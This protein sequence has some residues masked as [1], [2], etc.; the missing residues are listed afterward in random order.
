MCRKK[1]KNNKNTDGYDYTDGFLIHDDD[2]N[3]NKKNPVYKKKKNSIKKTY[4]T[5][6]C[7]IQ[8]EKTNIKEIQSL[9]DI[10]TLCTE[11]QLFLNTHHQK[12]KRILILDRLV[13]TI[14]S[15][16]QLNNMIGLTSIKTTITK[17]LL[18]IVQG[19]NNSTDF[20]HICLYG[21]P[22]C[23]K[24]YLSHI[25]ADIFRKIGLLTKGNVIKATRSDLIGGYLG[26][27]AIKTTKL[28]QTC[29][30]NVLILDEVY[31]LGSADSTGNGQ[32]DSFAKE[33]I[34]T[35]NFFLSEERH[36]FLCII[37]GYKEDVKNCFFSYNK[38]LERR[39]PW[40]YELDQYTITD[41]KHIFLKQI[42]D[43]QW[44]IL[45][46]HTETDTV[47][48]TIVFKKGN[49]TL[50]SNYGGDTEVLLTKCKIA[51][52]QRLFLSNLYNDHNNNNNNNNSEQIIKQ[53][54][55]IDIKKGYDEFLKSKEI[56]TNA[57]KNNKKIPTSV[58]MMYL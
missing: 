58:S 35:I 44:T 22:G 10:I 51:H 48:N 43:T 3:N 28:L 47:L 21:N 11:Y 37:F 53:L 18:Y 31:S 8:F 34:D 13:L 17:Q 40:I 19:L 46:D 1:N 49:E 42:K 55:N 33:C 26:S 39:F 7:T 20:N 52:S 41:I 14:D 24:T 12:A 45:S 30:G 29:K 15:L 50:F 27:T 9:Q 25:I 5:R 6:K 36:N 56:S 54:N 23:G 2:T 38:G 32:K 4:N 16:I 57:I